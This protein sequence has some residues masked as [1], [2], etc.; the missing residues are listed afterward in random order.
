ME[1]L[2][3]DKTDFSIYLK[4]TEFMDYNTPSV[5]EF[6]KEA[7]GKQITQIDRAIKLYYAVRDGIRYDPYR[8]DLSREGLT[9]SVVLER[10]AA[11]CIPKA[12]LLAAV[13]R[14]QG[15][16]SRLGFADVV[17]HLSSERMRKMMKTNVFAFH[18]YTELYLEGQW[19]KATPAF[20]LSLCEATGVVPLEFDGRNHSQFQQYD[21][22]GNRHMEYILDRGQYADLP[23]EEMLKIFM[24]FYGGT[25]T[26]DIGRSTGDFEKDLAIE[27]DSMK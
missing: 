11:F 8:F 12:V 1:S 26:G 21:V 23:Y 15:I 24:E 9:A 3:P 18:G 25:I 19:V 17:N 10:K 4:P 14:A 27:K 7:A 13:A 22:R 5:S 16:P 2:M 6:A 20:N